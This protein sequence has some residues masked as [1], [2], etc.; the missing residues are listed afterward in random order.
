MYI[1]THGQIAAQF[2]FCRERG[3]VPRI[4]IFDPTCL[5]MTIAHHAFEPLPLGTILLLVF[6]DGPLL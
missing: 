1:N 2:D 6:N 3:L 4:V 5:R